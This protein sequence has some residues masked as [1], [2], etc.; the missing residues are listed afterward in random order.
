MSLHSIAGPRPLL[1]LRSP[2]HH[3]TTPP[4][5]HTTPL[6]VKELRGKNRH[7]LM[8]TQSGHTGMLTYFLSLGP[9]MELARFRQNSSG[10]S[11]TANNNKLRRI[12]KL[13]AFLGVAQALLRFWYKDATLRTVEAVIAGTKT[14]DTQ[15]VSSLLRPTCTLLDISMFFSLGLAGL[16]LLAVLFTPASHPEGEDGGDGSDKED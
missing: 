3:S 1:S 4:H 13:H 12:I 9:T 16:A 7:R 11:W 8:K 5:H 15:L 6:A 2:P 14:P 10:Q